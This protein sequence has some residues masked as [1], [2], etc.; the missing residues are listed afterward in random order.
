L[1]AVQKTIGNLKLSD[2]KIY[3][4]R[5]LGQNYLTGAKEVVKRFSKTYG[6]NEK[7]RV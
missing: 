1:P 7:G 6:F 5:L 2:A 4:N 3:A